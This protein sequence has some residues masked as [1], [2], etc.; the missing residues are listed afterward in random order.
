MLIQEHRG[1]LKDEGQDDGI[2]VDGILKYI[3][4]NF[5]RL[6]I[7]DMHVFLTNHSS[8]HFCLTDAHWSSKWADNVDSD[9]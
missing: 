5:T 6:Y 4:H 9:G 8:A 1:Q 3:F 2:E 7:L